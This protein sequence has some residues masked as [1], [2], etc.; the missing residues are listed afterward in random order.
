M[1]TTVTLLIL[2]TLFSLNIA[3]L[4]F[5]VAVDYPDG[6]RASCFQKEE[7]FGDIAYSPDGTR[8]A[9][10][11]VIGIWLYDTA[12]R[13]EVGLITGHTDMVMSLA[14]SPDGNT[15][16]SAG[17]PFGRDD[18]MVRL[19]DV[20]TGAQ[21]RTLTGHTAGVSS[22]AFSPDGNTLA[23]GSWD[24]TVRLW[25]ANT[26]AQKRT[27]TGHTA[28]VSSVAFSPDG[29]TLASGGWDRTVRLWDANTGAQKRTLT[30]HQGLV[31]SVAFSPDGNTLASGSWDRTVRLWDVNTGTQRRTFIG[32]T[33]R[34]VQVYSVAFS[35][36]GKTL[37]SASGNPR[38]RDDKMVRLWDVNTGA[39]KR[40]LTGHQGLVG[41]LA[42]SPDGNTLASGSG[43]IRG[44]VDATVL[45]WEL[46]LFTPTKIH[47]PAT[48]PNPVDIEPMVLIPAGEL[49]MGSNDP[50]AENDEQPVHT[51]HVEAFYIDKYEV[52]NAQYKK[53]IDA[54]P[55]WSKKYLYAPYLADWNGNNYPHGKANHPVVH[56]NWYAAMAYAKWAGKRLPTEAEW[57][58]AAR[59]G[60]VGKKYP[61]GDDIDSSKANYDLKVSDTTRVGKYPP[62]GYGL[63][64]MA[65]NVWEWC[66]DAYDPDFYSNSPRRNPIAGHD[67]IAQVTS[68]FST[69]ETPRVLRGGS[70]YNIPVNLRVASRY[71][72]T[73]SGTLDGSGFRCAKAQ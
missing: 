48:P 49:Q 46:T 17:N 57:E 5:E 10:A 27:L 38:R 42:F 66:L 44:R 51:V 68:D 18:K 53:F 65:G 30:G 15:L 55:R 50:E 71:W 28:G 70:W 39:Q 73:P 35:P 58:Y 67:N 62:N 56:V 22:V 9:V 64:D 31:S 63:Y 11:G 60:L 37:A 7:I 4:I 72:N 19:W 16:A 33:N 29:N 13:Q 3:T 20:N 43:W 52:T 36:D 40:T 45:L 6:A 24:R 23:S 26:G 69:V 61:W 47:P 2:L 1:K 41:S 21:K 59:G 14:F 8:L 32:H 25:D 54:N 12:A 34:G